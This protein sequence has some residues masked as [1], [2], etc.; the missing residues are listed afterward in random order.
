MTRYL[1]LIIISFTHVFAQVSGNAKPKLQ[2]LVFPGWGEQTMGETKLAQSF[3]IS[4]AMIW[5]F[6]IGS[7]Q[8][9]NWYKSDYTAFATLHA[10]V[11]MH[12]KS[13]LFA[14]N[15]GHYD[16]FEE[17]NDT[18]ER[19]RL[20]DDKYSDSKY[21]WQWDSKINRIKYDKMRI[22]S[23]TAS[24]YAR[25]AVSGLILHRLLSLIDVIYLERQNQSVSMDT[26]IYG[27]WDNIEMRF[28][29]NF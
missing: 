6:Y 10:D 19:Q 17:Y 12:Q 16:N 26:R 27:N 24:K 8:T 7:V 20:P 15:L 9:K 3:F 2:S 11:D 22:K 4:E 13:Y 5:L 29:F 1:I 21:D 28:S 14:V 25:F 23:V 18:K